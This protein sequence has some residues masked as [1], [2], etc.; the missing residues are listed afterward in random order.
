MFVCGGNI[1]GKAWE[2]LVAS[3]K[4]AAIVVIED[5]T[6][7]SINS[8][9]PSIVQN[10]QSSE[11]LRNPGGSAHNL[12]ALLLWSAGVTVAAKHVAPAR[13]TV[14]RRLGTVGTQVGHIAVTRTVL[15]GDIVAT[16]AAKQV[17]DNVRLHHRL[18]TMLQT[19]NE[20]DG[21]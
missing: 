19:N 20:Q 14:R 7:W 6:G 8:A 17:V 4:A 12:G 1:E 18:G 3:W 21:G 5:V 15:D 13:A 16:V 11:I 2:A 9:F 10:Q